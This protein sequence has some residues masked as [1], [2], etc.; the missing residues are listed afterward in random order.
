VDVRTGARK[1]EHRPVIVICHG[2]KGFKDWGF[3]PRLAERLATAGFTAV[4]FNL[5]GSGVSGGDVFD[6]PERWFR[7][8][9]SW[10]LADV[11]TVVDWAVA[12][13]APWVGLLGHSRGGALAILQAARDPRVR[14]LVTWNAV[15][16]FLRW[17][18]EEI[19]RW[20]RDGRIDV[21]N[22]RTGQVLPIG[23]D[24][25][26]DSDTHG[27]ELDVLGAARRISVPWLLVHALADQTVP[28]SVAWTLAGRSAGGAVEPWLV[29]G[30]DHTFGIRHPWAGS[31]PA[32]DRVIERTTAHLAG[33]L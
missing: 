21:V 16:H 22:A 33:A 28:A 27:A 1:G 4:T 32:F 25:L 7:Q 30:A 13:G 24:A 29:D 8:R 15:D 17:P 2:F 19:A 14:A 11:G 18:Q 3:F 6:E 12:G 9:P 26:D 20:R 10:D 5:S 31:T 23:R